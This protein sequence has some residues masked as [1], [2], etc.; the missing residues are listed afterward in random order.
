VLQARTDGRFYFYTVSIAAK[1]PIVDG[2]LA[3]GIGIASDFAPYLLV[4]PGAV[5]ALAWYRLLTRR[6]VLWCG[7]LLMALPASLLPFAKTGGYLNNLMPL[8]V[9]APVAAFTALGDLVR[10][11]PQRSASALHVVL[12]M[13]VA[14]YEHARWYDPSRF[15]VTPEQ[16]AAARHV[17]AEIAALDGS[18][19]IPYFPFLAI[20]N[21]KTTEQLHAMAW[22][23]ANLARVKNLDLGKVL[24]D[25][26]PEYVVVSGAEVSFVASA[27][28][29]DYVV[30]RPFSAHA[31]TLVPDREGPLAITV[32]R[33]PELRRRTLFSFESSSHHGWTVRG[34]AFGRAPTA[35][36]A[37]AQGRVI[38]VVG[39]RLANSYASNGGDSAVGS[40]LS[41]EFVLDRN[42]LALRV[43]GGA[44]AGARVELRVGER[45]VATASGSG[46]EV[47][48]DVAWDV[49]RFAG[50]T[51]RLAVV[52]ETREPWGHVM[53][54]D[55]RLFD[56][57]V[58]SFR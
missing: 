51:A 28:A 14:L 52:D 58:G 46:T 32:R 24:A 5:L 29:R 56:V 6:T 7:M 42:R 49:S 36:G 55:V 30:T 25:L 21:G 48:A 38:G 1:H 3:E 35:G 20:R 37:R 13:T 50:R 39:N 22:Y 12:A 41:P 54:D 27:I 11:L 23:D 40:L 16:T 8:A 15:T 44:M 10:S 26:A 45:V 53:V 18:V 17:G 34:K 43:G 4:I 47:L 57:P 19:L 9:L 31:T 2:R 33:K